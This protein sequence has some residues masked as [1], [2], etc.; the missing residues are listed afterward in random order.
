MIRAL[1]EVWAAF[2]EA[3]REGFRRAQARNETRDRIT[4]IGPFDEMDEAQ[5]K[6]AREALHDAM[7]RYGLTE[8]DRRHQAGRES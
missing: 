8:R 4:L 7:H 1:R 2:W 6:A 5:R 3:F